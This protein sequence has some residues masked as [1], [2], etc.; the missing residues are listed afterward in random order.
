M[1]DG[2]SLAG[3]TGPNRHERVNTACAGEQEMAVDI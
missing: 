1:G 3:F 2:M